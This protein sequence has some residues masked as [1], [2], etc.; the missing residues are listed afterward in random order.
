MSIFRISSGV[1]GRPRLGPCAPQ[2]DGS[3][4][5]AT[6][7]K[8]QAYLSV[9][10]LHRPISLN[11]PTLNAVEVVPLAW[12]ILSDPASSGWLRAA[13][14][15]RGPAHQRGGAPIPVPRQAEP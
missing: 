13:R 3:R 15:V 14:L 2:T 7:G 6:T 5:N 8:R 10:I 11:A 1:S 9:D 4:K 12:R